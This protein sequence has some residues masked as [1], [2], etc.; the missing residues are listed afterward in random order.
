MNQLLTVA[1]GV[2]FFL[3]IMGCVALH[4]IGHMVPAKLFGVKVPKYFVGFGKTLWS[5]TRGETEYGL[6][7]FPLGGF[8]QLLGMYP[9]RRPDARNTRLQRLADADLA[10][11]EDFLEV[12]AAGGRSRRTGMVSTTS[13]AMSGNGWPT[14]TVATPPTRPRAGA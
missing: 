13:P 6:K 11:R 8:V 5:T 12:I 9:P 10:V 4:E 3:A 2:L 7:V 14:T 1:F